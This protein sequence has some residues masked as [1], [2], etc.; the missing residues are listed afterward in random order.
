MSLTGLMVNTK[1]SSSWWNWTNANFGSCYQNYSSN[2]TNYSKER[3]L[4]R[5]TN[6]TNICVYHKL[7][8][9]SSTFLLIWLWLKHTLVRTRLYVSS[10]KEV[11]WKS[12]IMGS[13]KAWECIC[14]KDSGSIYKY[15]F[16]NHVF[17]L[18]RCWGL[19]CLV[20][21]ESSLSVRVHK[22]T[23]MKKARRVYWC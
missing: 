14:F 1:L 3:Y 19:F 21:N 17:F 10:L 2:T 4:V 23:C 5:V 16:S 12:S 22:S 9:R 11:V 15:S 20:Y 18:C 8:I 7:K 6:L 13:S